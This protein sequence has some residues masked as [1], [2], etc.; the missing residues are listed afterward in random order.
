MSRFNPR[1]HAFILYIKLSDV[2]CQ[3]LIEK[4]NIPRR[5]AQ[6][7]I[8]DLELLV[9]ETP[10]GKDQLLI[11]YPWLRTGY[12]ILVNVQSDKKFFGFQ[13][14]LCELTLYHEHLDT[15][16]ASIMYKKQ[17]LPGL[18]GAYHQQDHL[19]PA[20][21]IATQSQMSQ[22]TQPPTPIQA[23]PPSTTNAGL[24]PLPPVKSESKKMA[25][26]PVALPPKQDP[27]RP[28][29]LVPEPTDWSK[30]VQKA[31]SSQPTEPLLS[32]Q[33][34][35][36]G[37][38]PPNLSTLSPPP[39]LSNPS[40]PISDPSQPIQETDL[41]L[42]VG[43]GPDDQLEEIVTVPMPQA[44]R[45]QIQLQTQIQTQTQPPLQPQTKKSAAPIPQPARS[46]TPRGVAI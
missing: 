7:G 34:R 44:S 24:Q 9:A 18:P 41:E 17:P 22:M 43:P 5:G 32:Q 29:L 16:H 15:Y 25:S 26:T 46:R 37:I 45:S 36:A 21:L 33:A 11:Q 1:E 23:P 31:E 19:R 12:P 6:I 30:I 20:P 28:T 14:V 2:R 40:V 13:D 4:F 10:G 8:Q 42:G 39:N 38:A 35:A 3:R 27:E